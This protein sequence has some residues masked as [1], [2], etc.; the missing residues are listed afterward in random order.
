MIAKGLLEKLELGEEFDKYNS[1]V[2]GVCEKYADMYMRDEIDYYE[3]QKLLE[4][5][6]TEEISRFTLYL[7]FLLHS[8]AALLE[9]Y[10]KEGISEEIFYASMM[11]FRYKI[12]ECREVEG[13]FGIKSY[14]WYNGFFKKLR[15]TFGR[16]QFDRMLYE[17]EPIE[18]AR[19]IVF[20]GDFV[21]NC[22]IPSS[23]PLLHEECIESY[24]M[25]YEFFKDKLIDGVLPIICWSWLLYPK[26]RDVFGIDSNVCRFA[27]DYDIYREEDT[28]VFGDCWR[29]FGCD[30]N[31]DISVLPERTSMQRAFKNYIKN[32]GT[33]GHA[34]GI[35][36]FD[37]EKV[38]TRNRYLLK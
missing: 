30:Y 31:G 32:N 36:L 24:K 27:A 13:V 15:H 14:A 4:E 8:T 2:G 35:L 25:A 23:G 21:L 26:Y 1:L 20:E 38:L 6:E 28:E 5:L 17:G 7:I 19:C 37:G 18:R 33:Y 29:V 12:R 9:L 34:R 22:H 11:D 10:G 16:L 3:A